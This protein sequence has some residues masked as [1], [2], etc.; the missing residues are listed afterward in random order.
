MGSLL[1]KHYPIQ[2]ILSVFIQTTSINLRANMVIFLISLF[3]F[4]L[5]LNRIRLTFSVLLLVE[6][7]ASRSFQQRKA[8][9]QLS[10]SDLCH[11]NYAFQEEC[12]VNWDHLKWYKEV[13]GLGQSCLKQQNGTEKKVPTK[14]PAF[15]C[16]TVLVKLYLCKC[17]PLL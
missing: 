12:E 9:E 11:L 7:C 13:Y 4:F 5:F 8:N 14:S 16:S 17:D 2:V 1:G 15:P 6:I 3:Y 10:S